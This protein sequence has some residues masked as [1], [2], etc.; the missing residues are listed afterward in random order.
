LFVDPAARFNP[1][2]GMRRFFYLMN[3]NFFHRQVLD[4]LLDFDEDLS[5]H[6]ANSLIYILVSQGRVAAAVSKGGL[7]TVWRELHRSGL[8]IPE[9]QKGL[10]V[11]ISNRGG[12]RDWINGASTDLMSAFRIALT[13]TPR[14]QVSPFDKLV[15]ECLRRKMMLF[16][17]WDR[18]DYGEITKIVEESGVATR[19]LDSIAAGPGRKEIDQE[20]NQI[21]DNECIRECMY[22]Y[23]IH[24]LKSYD[25]CVLKWKS[26]G[27]KSQG[28]FVQ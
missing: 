20:L 18:H 2:E 1:E 24:T 22:F 8:M 21:A 16:T 9:L 19:I 11:R 15:S 13:N 25:K 23:Y 4:D 14:D 17:A 3:R 12:T 28:L 7:R 10:G 26:R 5:N 27:M 6:T